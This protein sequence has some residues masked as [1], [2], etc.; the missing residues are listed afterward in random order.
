[1]YKNIKS[2]DLNLVAGQLGLKAQETGLFA[3][4]APAAALVGEAAVLKKVFELKQ[5]ELGGP[6]ETPKGIYIIKLKERK[7]SVVP[8][9]AE[10]K[11]VI[12]Q[13][14]KIV[15]SLDLAKKKAED[16]AKQFVAKAALKTQ[17]T[18]SF[19][20]S[21][22]GDLPNIGNAPE[23]MEAAFKLTAAAPAV[24]TAYKVGGSWYA[25]RLKQRVEAP[26]ADFEKGREELKKKILPK[27]QDEALS[28]WIKELRA[29]AKIEIN[30]ALEADK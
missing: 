27:K 17:T 13:K 22:K 5:G 1:L 14:A 9:L 29:K 12:E 3:A 4:N 21:A 24:D 6:V 25:V 30:P 28:A 15:K 19:G 8:P 7:D 16:A 23:L 10:I 2:G 20:F 18:G 11:T 26:K